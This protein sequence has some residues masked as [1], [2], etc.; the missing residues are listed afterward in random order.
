MPL[1]RLVSAFAPSHG[2]SGILSVRMRN[3][4]YAVQVPAQREFILAVSLSRTSFI[5]VQSGRPSS[6]CLDSCD[7]TVDDMQLQVART[8]YMQDRSTGRLPVVSPV[9]EISQ[10]SIE[11][12][13]SRKT[14]FSPNRSDRTHETS[15]PMSPPRPILRAIGPTYHVCDMESTAITA[16]T[17]HETIP[18]MPGGRRLMSPY[19]C[20]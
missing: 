1:R 12:C 15:K 8:L 16:A 11:Q 3:G 5:T 6:G 17:Q 19:A 13:G 20:R 7:P 18:A 2:E 4:Y 9:L 10:R 14:S